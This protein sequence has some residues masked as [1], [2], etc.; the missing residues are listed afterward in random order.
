MKVMLVSE[1][2]HFQHL[3]HN[4]NDLNNIQNI[5]K[6]E[7]VNIQGYGRFPTADDH[8]L[9]AIVHIMKLGASRSW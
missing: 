2:N 7:K 3:L 6:H 1:Q 4:F 5:I 8:L 9:I